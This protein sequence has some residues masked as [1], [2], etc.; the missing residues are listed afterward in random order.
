MALHQVA[1]Q[2][3]VLRKTASA[4]VAAKVS[5]T[6]AFIFHMLQ[7]A[8]FELVTTTTSRTLETEFLVLH[9]IRVSRLSERY[10]LNGRPG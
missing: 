3:D 4:Q 7:Q 1:A 9:V 2:T 5:A 8:G 10:W 6:A